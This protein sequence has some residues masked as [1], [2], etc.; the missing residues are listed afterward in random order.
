MSV[1][2]SGAVL[3]GIVW[4]IHMATDELPDGNEAGPR[5]ERARQRREVERIRK[6]DEKRE[7]ERKRMGIDP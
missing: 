5:S 2:L 7:R 1:L 3:I 6:L 4:A